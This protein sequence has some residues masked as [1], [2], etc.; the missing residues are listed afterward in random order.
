MKFF[1][2][3]LK[4]GAD[5][6]L[7]NK[8]GRT[9]YAMAARAGKRDIMGWLAHAGATTE[10]SDVD[11]FIA[12]CA[13]GDAGKAKELLVAQPDL[14]DTFT[15]RDRGEICETAAAGNLDGVRTMLDVGWDIDTRNVVWSETP[16]HR[17]AFHANLDLVQLLV[18][19]GADLTITDRTY[20][21]TPLGWAQH[22]EAQEVVEYFRSL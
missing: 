5:L 1:D 11:A 20:H 6:N 9:A 10:M 3:L 16:L 22:A 14:F 7:P 15:D 21:S 17:A 19:R 18:D 13:A 12:A 8:E 2:L 4:H